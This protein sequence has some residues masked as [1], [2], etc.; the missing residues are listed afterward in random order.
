MVVIP[1]MRRRDNSLLLWNLTN[2]NSPVHSF[3]GH[4]D[5]VLEF[6]W[7]KRAGLCY[8]MFSFQ[9]LRIARF[10]FLTY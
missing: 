10:F 9:P 7:G 6:D 3:V 2:L 1:P 8:F 5:I 4:A